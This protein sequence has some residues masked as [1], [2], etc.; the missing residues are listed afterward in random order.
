LI[1]SAN[2]SSHD[3]LGAYCGSYDEKKEATLRQDTFD[4]KSIIL[5]VE[6]FDIRFFMESLQ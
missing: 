5:G 4:L 3:V 6:Y 2:R 1:I